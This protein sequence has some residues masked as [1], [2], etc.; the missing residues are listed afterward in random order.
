MNESGHEGM[1][2]ETSQA[3]LGPLSASLSLPA[4][5]SWGFLESFARLLGAS[6]RFLARPRSPGA[7]F[8]SSGLLET[9]GQKWPLGASWGFPEPP[10]ISEASWDLTGLPGAC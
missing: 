1:H 6:Q 5:A 8:G 9:L 7:S 4:R 3:Y 2:L 10:G